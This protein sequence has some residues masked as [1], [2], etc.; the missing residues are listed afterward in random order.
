M[1]FL[2]RH[3]RQLILGLISLICC[4]CIGLSIPVQSSLLHRSGA[5][6]LITAEA[7]ML[8]HSV[9]SAYHKQLFGKPQTVAWEITGVLL[10]FPF[11]ALLTLFILGVQIQSD[12]HPI[13]RAFLA[14]QLLIVIQ[15]ILMASYALGLVL[16]TV[17]T[18]F[19]FDSKVCAR[20]IDSSPSPFPVRFLLCRLF[21]CTD[22]ADSVQDLK[23]Q[24][25]CLRGCGCAEKSKPELIQPSFNEHD[26]TTTC[27]APG[28]P[29]LGTSKPL[30]MT[31]VRLPDEAQ[32]RSSITLTFETACLDDDVEATVPGA[33]LRSMSLL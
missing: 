16:V 19:L 22:S 13:L 29:N 25:T 10:L 30:P 12:D 28:I 21:L 18:L 5:V 15:T 20:N 6:L 27:S 24:H 14:L 9:A 23:D 2:F 17:A 7:L 31:L 26:L 32:R 8:I 3:F 1:F 4:T 11:A 33:R